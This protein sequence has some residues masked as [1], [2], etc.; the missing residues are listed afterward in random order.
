VSVLAV[1]ILHEAG[2]QLGGFLPRLGGALVLLLL[3]LLIVRLLARLLLGA[4]RGIGLDAL[5]ERAGVAE[6][7]ERA[8]LGRS[9]SLVVSVAVRISLSVVVVF[10]ALSLLGLQFLSESLNRGVLLMP[11]LL[12]A[13]ALLLA[14]VVLGGYA[15][16]RIER[17][18]Y[19]LDFPVPLGAAAQL[20]VI[21]IFAITAAAQIAISTIVL[22][23]LIGIVLAGVMATVALA[24]G[25]GGRD[26]AR[27]V[28]AGRYAQGAFAVGQEISVGA[29]RGRIIAIESAS[30]V[31]QGAGHSIRVPNQLLLEG[32][33]VVHERASDPPDVQAT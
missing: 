7:L 9:L 32:P 4:L 29:T 31:L 28:S 18:S 13:G 22:L 2:N 12:I 10:A 19:Q 26:F 23:I 20:V 3:G 33:V 25:L 5:S 8:R 24:F 17:L 11:K 15:R 27:A 30:T 21:S 16:E 1:G 14:G 6:V